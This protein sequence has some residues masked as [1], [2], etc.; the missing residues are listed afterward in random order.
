V[1]YII[2]CHCLENG[3]LKLN[4]GT[5][6]NDLRFIEYR[7]LNSNLSNNLY[8]DQFRSNEYEDSIY[9]NSIY[10]VQK[11]ITRMWLDPPSNEN[12]ALLKYVRHG[13]TS[14]HL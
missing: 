12:G 8:E 5:L 13:L 7:T 9:R 6:K 3:K 4:F 2:Y 10:R 1:D 11:G 14:T